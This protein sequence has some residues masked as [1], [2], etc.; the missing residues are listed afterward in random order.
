MKNFFFL[1]IIIVSI[2]SCKPNKIVDL[3]GRIRLINA[4]STIGDVNMK[5][6]Y[7]TIYATDVQYL[8]YSLFREYI[9]TKH[10]LQIEDA[11]GNILIDSS[12]IVENKNAYTVFVY[13]SVGTPKLKIINEEFIAPK[14]SGCKIRFLNLSKDDDVIDVYKNGD[15][16]VHFLAYANGQHSDYNE[17]ESGLLNF[18]V[19][20]SSN[21]IIFYNYGHQFK[22]GNYYTMFLKGTKSS[23]LKDSIGLFTIENNQNY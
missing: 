11:F 4:S 12:L 17:I 1:L 2:S 13:D 20:Y 6:D 3:K 15:S 19:N 7:E 8:N 21:G 18:N 10:K 5:V 16:L 23:S 22:P 9:A 14:G